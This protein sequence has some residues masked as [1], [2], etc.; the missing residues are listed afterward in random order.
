MDGKVD[1]LEEY[2]Y[3]ESHLCNSGTKY[4]GEL[5][6][7]ITKNKDSPGSDNGTGLFQTVCS[8][9]IREAYE[10]LE[11][12]VR[13]AALDLHVAGRAPLGS[14]DR[15]GGARTCTYCL[16]P[17]GGHRRRRF[18]AAA[19]VSARVLERGLSCAAARRALTDV[20]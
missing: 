9:K 19:L 20:R 3:I 1:D 13:A 16:A 10:A 5:T 6:E 2:V 4:Y 18:G 11:V 17:R 12:S 14:S 8:F 15:R 7:Q